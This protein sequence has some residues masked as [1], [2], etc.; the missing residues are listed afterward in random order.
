MKYC[1]LFF[2]LF[3]ITSCSN[4]LELEKRFDCNSQSLSNT[5]QFTDFKKNYK[6]TIPKHW[7]TS[8]YYNTFQSEIFTADT[9]KQLTE[10]Y[11][12]DTSHNLGKLN[13]DDRFIKKIDSVLTSEKLVFVASGE[14][15]FNK[16]PSFWYL[17]KGNQ[18]GFTYHQL[19]FYTKLSENTY[20]STTTKV[21]GDKNINERFCESI[22][23]QKT[24]NFLE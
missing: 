13:F 23:I 16:K 22:S 21:Y 3:S 9:T 14:E 19:D 4:K 17:S 24:V 18:Q 11:I 20:F 12:L 8:L 6:I 15:L 5:K 10:T 1:L 7:K 2:L